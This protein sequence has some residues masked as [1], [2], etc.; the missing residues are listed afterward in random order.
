MTV[1]R[2]R[3]PGSAQGRLA[4]AVT[5]DGIGA[6]ARPVFGEGLSETAEAVGRIGGA[7]GVFGSPE[8]GTVW[9]VELPC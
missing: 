7:L 6:G 4:V 2:A 1:C 5:D 9:Q 3:R 8:G